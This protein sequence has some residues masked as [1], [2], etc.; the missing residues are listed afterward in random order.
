VDGLALAEDVNA[1]EELT[2]T[3]A[4]EE[5]QF[6]SCHLELNTPTSTV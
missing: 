4:A 1:I 2:V 5:F 6:H 3:V